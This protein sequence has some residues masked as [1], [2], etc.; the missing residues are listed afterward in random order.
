[1]GVVGEYKYHQVNILLILI[2]IIY[3]VG[4]WVRQLSLVEISWFDL[5]LIKKN[6]LN[7]YIIQRIS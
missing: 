3:M 4:K 1:M 7:G 5:N 2:Q 6:S